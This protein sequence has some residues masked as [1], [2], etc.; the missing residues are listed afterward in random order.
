M[1][2]Y[3]DDN[4]DIGNQTIEGTVSPYELD[5][6]LVMPD[7]STI[8]VNPTPEEQAADLDSKLAEMLGETDTPVLDPDAQLAAL[9]AE[10]ETR[11][12]DELDSKLDALLNGE[13]LSNNTIL[14]PPPEQN[15]D[16][17]ILTPPPAQNDDAIILTPPPEQND[18]AIILTPPPV[19]NDDAIILTPPTEQNN[20][21]I[22][23]AQPEN[24]G[25]TAT[26]STIILTPPPAESVSINNDAII[27]TPPNNDTAVPLSQP[28]GQQTTEEQMASADAE[29]ARAI[30]EH[31]QKLIEQAQA[32]QA[33]ANEQTAQAQAQ[34]QAQMQAHAAQQ[35]QM[36]AQAQ[37]AAQ[38]LQTSPT[39][40]THNI[41]SNAAIE[42]RVMMQQAQMMIQ[43]AQQAQLQAEQAAQAA[44]LQAEQIARTAQNV[45]PVMQQQP[46]A[47]GYYTDKEVDRLKNE[48]DS[49][50]ELVNK[51]TLQLAGTPA[52]A[53]QGIQIPPHV[54]GYTGDG[55]GY[56]K[57]QTELEGMRREILEKDLRDREKELERKQKE[58]ENNVKDIRPEMVQMSDSRDVAPVGG[59][60]GG[61]FIPLA[62]GVY[63]STKDKQV[64]VLTLA[65]GAATQPAS[66]PVAPKRPTAHRK[67]AR[68]AAR[69][70][71]R[72][73]ARRRP[74]PHGRPPRR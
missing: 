31:A 67:V 58:A 70:S 19:Q 57:L 22:I 3:R 59:G 42:A 28:A 43:Q 21:A 46:V 50:R 16:A 47:N 74:A 12:G 30:M 26:G 4:A 25:E 53:Q 62:N 63:Y 60:L 32:A 29:Q 15:N 18:D 9:M 55:D 37:Q 61:E 8:P 38:I 2:N 72:I 33:Q 36:Q 24:S 20:D 48:L 35:A 71:P 34:M 49:M 41:E 1:A 73:R 27:L 23:S 5:A 54:Y 10:T 11:I 40:Q 51:L 45:Q 39:V 7:G 6:E 69:R 44:R 66:Q 68:P 52:A 17:I 13:P 56:K 64:Y 14:T 65:S